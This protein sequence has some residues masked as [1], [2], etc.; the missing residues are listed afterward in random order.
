MTS[1]DATTAVLGVLSEVRNQCVFAEKILHR[2]QWRVNTVHSMQELARMQFANKNV[3][4]ASGT[5]EQR[6]KSSFQA[7]L[8]EPVRS[9]FDKLESQHNTDQ[10]QSILDLAAYLAGY[11]AGKNGLAA[12]QKMSKFGELLI[13]TCAGGPTFLAL[14]QG[15]A[16]PC[17][18]NEMHTSQGFLVMYRVPPSW[19][20]DF[21]LI[22]GQLRRLLDA[23][24][25]TQAYEEEEIGVVPGAVSKYKNRLGKNSSFRHYVSKLIA[26]PPRYILRVCAQPIVRWKM[27]TACF[28]WLLN[29]QNSA[30]D[31]DDLE[32]ETAIEE[33]R[34]IDI[35]E[36]SEILVKAM[37]WAALPRTADNVEFN[38][39]CIL[40]HLHH[41]EVW[42][43]DTKR[44]LGDITET[45]FA[46]PGRFEEQVTEA[47]QA[48]HEA[49]FHQ[50]FNFVDFVSVNISAEEWHLFQRKCFRANYE[51]P[52]SYNEVCLHVCRNFSNYVLMGATQT[53]TLPTMH[54]NQNT[55]GQVVSGLLSQ[56]PPTP[57]L[58]M[59]AFE[60]KKIYQRLT[61]L[62][63]KN[64]PCRDMVSKAAIVTMPQ[65]E[66]ESKQL[67]SF[68]CQP[69]Q[70][71][72]ALEEPAAKRQLSL[73]TAEQR[74]KPQGVLVLLA[75]LHMQDA[76][77]RESPTREDVFLE[78]QKWTV[79]EKIIHYS[80]TNDYVDWMRSIS[81][82]DIRQHHEWV[83]TI[84]EYPMQIDYERAEQWRAVT[85][86]DANAF[87]DPTFSSAMKAIQPILFEDDML[88]KYDQDVDRLH[89]LHMFMQKEQQLTEQESAA[90]S[91]YEATSLTADEMELAAAEAEEAAF[92]AQER[93]KEAIAE[94][95]AA[96]N[97]YEQASKEGKHQ[98]DRLT[99]LQ[100]ADRD[101]TDAKTAAQK[102]EDKAQTR[103]N[104]FNA[105]KEAQNQAENTLEDVTTKLK[106][107]EDIYDNLLDE[108]A[109]DAQAAADA[110]EDSMM[111][112]AL[113]TLQTP[114]TPQEAAKESNVLAPSS[115]EEEKSSSFLYLSTDSEDSDSEES[116]KP[117]KTFDTPQRSDVSEGAM[118]SQKVTTTPGGSDIFA[119]QV[120][121]DW[122]LSSGAKVPN[123]VAMQEIPP[124]SPQSKDLVAFFAPPD[125]KKIFDEFVRAGEGDLA[126][127]IMET[128]S[129][130]D[131]KTNLNAEQLIAKLQEQLRAA[132][133]QPWQDIFLTSTSDFAKQI[134]SVNL[135]TGRGRP[136]QTDSATSA[137]KPT[138]TTILHYFG[139]FAR[140]AVN[141]ILFER[142]MHP[143]EQFL[144]RAKFK[145]EDDKQL[146][147]PFVST[148]KQMIEFATELSM[149]KSNCGNIA[150]SRMTSQHGWSQMFTHTFAWTAETAETA[151]E[152]TTV[153]ERFKV[154]QLLLPE[155]ASAAK[156]VLTKAQVDTMWSAYTDETA[157]GNTVLSDFEDKGVDTQPVKYTSEN[158]QN[159]EQS[160]SMMTKCL[161]FDRRNWL[162]AC[163]V[164]VG[165][166]SDIIKIP[167]ASVAQHM[168]QRLQN[169]PP[170]ETSVSTPDSAEAKVRQVIA[171]Y[172]ESMCAWNSV[173]QALRM[174]FEA[175]SYPDIHKIAEQMHK[176]ATA[177]VKFQQYIHHVVKDVENDTYSFHTYADMYNPLI[178]PKS[179]EHQ[180][181]ERAKRQRAAQTKLA[182][183]MKKQTERL[184]RSMLTMETLMTA[185]DAAYETYSKAENRVVPPREGEGTKYTH[186][187]PGLGQFQDAILLLKQNVNEYQSDTRYERLA[188]YFYTTLHR[189]IMWHSA[190]T[191]TIQKYTTCQNLFGLDI[192]FDADAGKDEVK[193]QWQEWLFAKDPA[194]N[195]LAWN[196]SSFQKE[197]SKLTLKAQKKALQRWATYAAAV[198]KSQPSVMFADQDTLKAQVAKYDKMP[199]ADESVEE[200][201]GV[202]QLGKQFLVQNV[203]TQFELYVVG[204]KMLTQ[205]DLNGLP[206]NK[207]KRYTK[208][209]TQDDW[210]NLTLAETSRYTNEVHEMRKH[211]T[212][213]DF[214]K[215]YA[216]F[217]TETRSPHL[218]F[219]NA[220]GDSETFAL[221]QPDLLPTKNVTDFEPLQEW[222]NKLQENQPNLQRTTLRQQKIPDAKILQLFCWSAEHLYAITNTHWVEFAKKQKLYQ[223]SPPDHQQSFLEIDW[224]KEL[225]DEQQD[226]QD[227]LY[228]KQIEREAQEEQR[229]EARKKQQERKTLKEK[230]KM[231]QR[232]QKKR[233]EWATKLSDT[234]ISGMIVKVLNSNTIT[235]QKF[236]KGKV[237]EGDFLT[238]AKKIDGKTQ[239]FYRQIESV[240]FDT[241]TVTLHPQGKT[242]NPKD[243]VKQQYTVHQQSQSQINFTQ[244]RLLQNL[245][246]L[247]DTIKWKK[248][249]IDD[250][251]QILE[252]HVGDFFCE[253]A[254]T[255][256]PSDLPSTNH[257]L[258]HFGYK[259]YKFKKPKTQQ[260]KL[261]VN[262]QGTHPRALRKTNPYLFQIPYLVQD[263]FAVELRQNQPVDADET[264]LA[265]LQGQ[266]QCLIAN[267]L[268]QQT[269]VKKFQTYCSSAKPS[270]NFLDTFTG[271]GS[272]IVGFSK[273]FVDAMSPLDRQ[274]F[275]LVRV[276]LYLNTWHGVDVRETKIV[277]LIW[278]SDKKTLCGQVLR[279]ADKW[280]KQVQNDLQD[281]QIQTHK[282]NQIVDQHLITSKLFLPVPA[283]ANPSDIRIP[284]RTYATF[285][286]S[287]ERKRAL[288]VKGKNFVL[289][290]EFDSNG[291]D[292][293]PSFECL[294][295]FVHTSPE[296]VG[297]AVLEMLNLYEVTIP[298]ND[299]KLL[300]WVQKFVDNVHLNLKTAS[301]PTHTELLRLLMHFAYHRWMY[302]VQT[303]KRGEIT[304]LKKRVTPNDK[305]DIQRVFLQSMHNVLHARKFPEFVN[306]CRYRLYCE[307]RRDACIWV[308]DRLQHNHVLHTIA[309]KQKWSPQSLSNVSQPNFAEQI[310][311]HFQSARNQAHLHTAQFREYLAE[312]W[313]TIVQDVDTKDAEVQQYNSIS[314]LLQTQASALCSIDDGVLQKP[315]WEQDAT[316]ALIVADYQ[317]C[318]LGNTAPRVQATRL[319]QHLNWQTP[320]TSEAWQTVQNTLLAYATFNFY[321]RI[322]F[323]GAWDN[324]MN[325]YHIVATPQ[326][327][328]DFALYYLHKNLKE[329]FTE[330]MGKQTFDEWRLQPGK[331]GK[332][333]SQFACNKNVLVNLCV[334]ALGSVSRAV[335]ECYNHK[336]PIWPICPFQ[337]SNIVNAKFRQQNALTLQNWQ[338]NGSLSFTTTFK[339]CTIGSIA[340][341]ASMHHLNPELTTQELTTQER[342]VR[343][344]SLA[345]ACAA[346][347]NGDDLLFPPRSKESLFIKKSLR[348][349]CGQQDHPSKLAPGSLEFWCSSETQRFYWRDLMAVSST[350]SSLETSSP[351]GR[352]SQDS[353][354]V[355]IGPKYNVEIASGDR[356][357]MLLESE[358]WSQYFCRQPEK[359]LSV[360]GV[361]AV[362]EDAVVSGGTWHELHKYLGTNRYDVMLLPYETR[363]PFGFYKFTTASHLFYFKASKVQNMQTM[364]MESSIYFTEE[365]FKMPATAPS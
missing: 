290:T 362:T 22:L 209:L 319:I 8:V 57:V 130:P 300:E 197:W 35:Q 157:N 267:F 58:N 155:P 307:R 170:A 114:K 312:N 64:K 108:A 228:Q 41:T 149:Y 175:Q 238:I 341:L 338:T 266:K 334:N 308:L 219:E 91:V 1:S 18:A 65:F 11:K 7:N 156:S 21:K 274:M 126:T 72:L 184:E 250:V 101:L 83:S 316:A 137:S 248:K 218:W 17:K 39:E 94:Q 96:Q 44:K 46:S 235:L 138:K 313:E 359:A 261:H 55:A 217:L 143:H 303:F 336:N 277:P 71:I 100:E 36:S 332:A 335:L 68:F 89:K 229:I 90:E 27:A 47:E 163:N 322:Q 176:K 152:D 344:Q 54:C 325:N 10:Q 279:Y 23:E 80:D 269:H 357:Q 271:D 31:S 224:H 109:A 304:W 2:L 293:C 292:A 363:E 348:R 234:G 210:D 242:L 30:N 136:P 117:T 78:D 284:K 263:T 45:V 192:T 245:Q 251:K 249:A 115:L 59:A 331:E 216:K 125:I 337:T 354:D 207:T 181:Q 73:D 159:K 42:N 139:Q 329:G 167:S 107:A 14:L 258:A 180:E 215:N 12:F 314:E 13:Q 124:P 214:F 208:L 221:F 194:Y 222:L 178:A 142:P 95:I 257:L 3:R 127:Q 161:Y 87:S 227:L 204:Q 50:N 231:L 190:D 358:T 75:R 173:C 326:M 182:K 154:V 321:K 343:L 286:D 315:T 118:L 116:K 135:S 364:Q 306:A 247:P 252:G 236:D 5:L 220:A 287:P 330:T 97:A 340:V 112:D 104:L 51:R 350:D 25:D 226:K 291:V 355:T 98:Q 239:H 164:D 52:L 233:L 262:Q 20:T 99:E 259:I 241:H 311:E 134:A 275:N 285:L 153:G 82:E 174:E 243:I 70:E 110:T 162:L 202:Y 232:L 186:N 211:T 361:A 61:S 48:Y 356:L 253:L 53:T 9:F 283:P 230:Q 333:V 19:R 103:M 92:E 255:I 200:E 32:S 301:E 327:H 4:E 237:V 34:N 205:D 141:F 121:R 276:H 281:P 120:L 289:E 145:N 288:I 123:P 40:A 272:K 43:L 223:Q 201:E 56:T 77:I 148:T 33:P 296:V 129:I 79:F 85:M 185:Q 144:D 187:K 297:P 166:V 132:N 298:T 76:L 212:K 62:L 254:E 264:N 295:Q 67:M 102:A 240:D 119:Y 122:A 268:K 189:R 183:Q 105:A 171:M 60:V 146:L 225:H 346:D 360:F 365:A 150:M 196:L 74:S 113:A 351:I 15:F 131:W 317:L 198:S 177:K 28:N 6:A 169:D 347:P 16:S 294:T 339:G 195:P 37:A 111:S 260:V 213:A 133:A 349:T 324:N 199:V 128:L 305:H 193:I 282:H 328:L 69:W 49:L 256:K 93:L 147:R 203:F 352:N 88:K 270:Q 310:M 160:K 206:L 323:E 165:N 172:H 320:K 265:T 179:A 38:Q 244:N 188:Q 158:A 273:T 246:D 345:V 29:H 353:L 66:T 168:Q 81:F 106:E 299:K 151:A 86:S 278:T 84:K 24:H 191:W 309:H 280:I 318:R 302:N 140:K 26:S 342:L 63:F